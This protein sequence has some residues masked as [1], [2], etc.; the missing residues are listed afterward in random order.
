MLKTTALTIRRRNATPLD[1]PALTL[2]PGARTL[3]L[4]PSGA[5]KT[6]WLS[7]IGGLLP[8]DEGAVYYGEQDIYKLPGRRRD[9]WRGQHCGFVFQTL[10]LIPALTVRQNITLAASLAGLPIDKDR[11]D[12]LLEK[13]NLTAKA[14]HR[15]AALSQGEQQRAAIARAV[16][17]RP[18]I[19]LADEPTSALDDS[20]AQAVMDMLESCAADSKAALLVATHDSRLQNRFTNRITITPPQRTA[21]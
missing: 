2:A 19:I 18:A 21:A 10:H 17:N 13:L 5:G 16:L 1:F 3:L 20:H 4:G 9:R 15:P 12:F 6:T 7:A 8:P 11:I 14:G